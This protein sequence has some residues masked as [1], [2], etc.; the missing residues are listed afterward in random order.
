MRLDGRQFC[1][2]CGTQLLEN[3]LPIKAKKSAGM[4]AFLIS[5]IGVRKVVFE[6]YQSSKRHYTHRR[7]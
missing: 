7:L 3:P 6:S 4:L 2:S 1:I 5:I